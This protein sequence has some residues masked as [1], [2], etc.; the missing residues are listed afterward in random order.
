MRLT[1]LCALGAVVTTFT[2]AACN[3]SLEPR[4]TSEPADFHVSN[5][6]QGQGW[7]TV[8]HVWGREGRPDTSS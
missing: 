1:S 4:S 6:G 7:L 5:L 3:D 8:C 2:L